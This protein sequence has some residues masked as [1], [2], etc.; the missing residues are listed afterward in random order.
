[1]DL[2]TVISGIFSGH[3]SGI[4][5]GLF[6]GI[7]SFRCRSVVGETILL[8]YY[9]AIV[10]LYLYTNYILFYA[11]NCT[12]GSP[13]AEYTLQ[14]NTSV[15]LLISHTTA[16]YYYIRDSMKVCLST[17]SSSMVIML[18][19]LLLLFTLYIN[20]SDAYFE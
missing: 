14:F 8:K 4:F 19:L 3:F 7:F 16:F 20:F 13:V 6:S 2:S 9:F 5:S 12:T 18:V 1:M 11:S 15:H 17:S 10:V